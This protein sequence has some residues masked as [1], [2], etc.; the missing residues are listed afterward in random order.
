V[1]HPIVL[2]S[3]V[4]GLATLTGCGGDD[5]SSAPSVSVTA[6]VPSIADEGDLRRL[7]DRASMLVADRIDG[8]AM[9]GS[10]SDLAA[11]LGE[12]RDD[13]LD[14]AGELEATD[15]RSD[16][17]DERDRLVSA[18]RTVGDQLGE[19]QAKVAGEDSLLG[20][21]GELGDINSLDE[22]QRAVMDI[23]AALGA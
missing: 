22:L 3:F 8:L 5:T 1:R 10:V 7:A 12:T 16:L 14:L 19:A 17:E 13:A 15:V 11:Q 18:L 21:I 20:A 6:A 4:L 2:L 9:V 23:R